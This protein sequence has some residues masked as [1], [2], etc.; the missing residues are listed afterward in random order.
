MQNLSNKSKWIIGLVLSVF[1]IGGYFVGKYNNMVTMKNSINVQWSQ[2]ENQMQRR[3]DLVPQLVD[4]IKQVLKQEGNEDVYVKLAEAR[5]AYSGA[6]S[7]DNKVAAAEEYNSALSRLLA[8][9]ENYP[10]LKANEN[11]KDLQASVEGTENRLAV[12]RGRYNET[13]GAYNA[14]IL[15]F[16]NNLFANVFG[17]NNFE[18]FKSVEGSENAPNINNLFNN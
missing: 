2:V 17:F 9:T 18:T 12:E 16:P 1:I 5:S 11:I 6:S 14:Y 7:I 8:I 3:F 13:V 15:R 4:S 10:Q